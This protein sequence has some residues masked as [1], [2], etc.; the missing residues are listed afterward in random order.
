MLIFLTQPVDEI[1]KKQVGED[2]D[3]YVKVVVDITQ[4]IIAAGGKRHVDIEQLLLSRGSKHEDLWGGG[5]DLETGTV[6]FDS[7][8]NIRPA[9]GNTSREVLSAEIRSTMEKLIRAY[10]VSH[11]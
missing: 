1:T 7:M 10:F 5:I 9:Q 3:G 2:L 4:N 8:I 11:V 6:D